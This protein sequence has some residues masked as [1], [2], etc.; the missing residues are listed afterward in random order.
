MAYNPHTKTTKVYLHLFQYCVQFHQRG[1]FFLGAGSEWH[2]VQDGDQC[3]QGQNKCCCRWLKATCLQGQGETR[4][5]KHMINSE[6]N[7]DEY[8]KFDKTRGKQKVPKLPIDF[9]VI[10]EDEWARCWLERGVVA[11]WACPIGQSV[12]WRKIGSRLMVPNEP[13]DHI[14]VHADNSCWYIDY[15]WLW[16][17]V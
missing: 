5:N 12:W 9:N 16:Y 15:G 2:E 1:K 14:F 3:L 11:H 8:D 13:P 10:R 4:W 17:R 6:K 7:L